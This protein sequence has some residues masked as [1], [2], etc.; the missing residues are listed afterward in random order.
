MATE[1]S[2][3]PAVKRSTTPDHVAQ[4]VAMREA[5]YTVLAISEELG[6]S[7]RTLHRLFTEHGARKGEV[8][9]S[10]IEAA[11]AALID[12]VMNDDTIRNEV[13]SQI[14]D[15]LAHSRHLREIIVSAAEHL[16]ATTLT[17]AALVMRA[18]A[19]YSVALKNTSDTLRHVLRVERPEAHPD[20]AL[21]ELVITELSQ[22]DVIR[23]RTAQGELEVAAL[24]Y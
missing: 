6:V 14:A 12:R 11:R 2:T 10:L 1:K 17:E 18:A 19:A 22:E 3:I 24:T 21:P 8:K 7:V 5:G 13:A 9:Q 15:D 4:A 23:L 16:K 20:G